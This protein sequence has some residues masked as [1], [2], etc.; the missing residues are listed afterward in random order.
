MP[1]V[2]RE[3]DVVSGAL[4]EPGQRGA[5]RLHQLQCA[6][7][8]RWV[9]LLLNGGELR[10]T[11]PPVRLNA[12]GALPAQRG[13][14]GASPAHGGPRDPLPLLRDGVGPGGLP[15]PLRGLAQRWD[16]RDACPGGPSPLGGVGVVVL[17]N[18][19][20]T[21]VPEALAYR[22]LDLHLGRPWRGTG[23]RSRSRAPRQAGKPRPGRSSG[24]PSPG[25]RAP[26]RLF[27]S[28]ATK[29]SYE[30]DLY[31]RVT[32]REEGGRLLLEDFAGRRATL[33]HWHSRHLPGHVGGSHAGRNFVT[34]GLDAAGR[35]A[36]A[37]HGGLPAG[38]LPPGSR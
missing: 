18:F 13:L 37:D 16:R 5:R 31:G 35:P 23:W 15:G 30:N 34:F 1:H 27:R 29:G 11:A 17:V 2:R 6:E 38:A 22:V 26:V 32:V 12:P 36:A 25:Q 20:G 9:R 28:H 14:S 3:A 7:M 33:E 24:W 8:A 10:G 21:G 4:P 19:T